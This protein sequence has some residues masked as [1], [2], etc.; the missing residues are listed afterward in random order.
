MDVIDRAGN[1]R[2]DP[3]FVAAILSDPG[4]RIVPLRAGRHLVEQSAAA[5]RAL[6]PSRAAAPALASTLDTRP[7]ALLG[8]A[9]QTPIVAV[10]LG[11]SDEV[12]FDPDTLG[13]T[14]AELRAV[15]P[16]LARDEAATLI[17]AR[18]LINWRRRQLFCGVCGAPCQPIEA[19]NVMQCSACA[20]HHFPR[21]DPAVIMLVR[22]R[23]RVLLARSTRFPGRMFSVLAGFVEPGESLEG[24]VAR[25]VR[26][27]C[28]VHLT[29]IAYHSSQPWPFPAS[30]MLGFTAETTDDD[31][32]IDDDEIVEAR[33]FTRAD[34]ADR[35]NR[36]FSIPPRFSIARALIED[37][38]NA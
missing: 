34:I 12:D 32:T 9:R 38:C 22:N 37:W 17:H 16:M 8:L 15:A 7:W 21:T 24:A 4:T 3:E 28:G 30:I 19:G 18:G 26:E 1:R 27:E 35:D 5:T 31:I 2:K 23:D 14:F 10:D 36:D 20:T 6:F 29:N 25:E 11:E 13:G 33:W